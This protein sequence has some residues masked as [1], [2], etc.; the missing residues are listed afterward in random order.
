MVKNLVHTIK[1]FDEKIKKIM[2]NGL[3]FSL[4]I[5]IIAAFI[6]I[7][8][9]S[10]SHSNFIYHIGI[11]VMHLSISFGVSFFA[12]ALAIDKIKKDLA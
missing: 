3:Y 9:I 2:V 4:I 5:S 10:F 6:L 11:E 12:S 8:Y 7:Y 1:G